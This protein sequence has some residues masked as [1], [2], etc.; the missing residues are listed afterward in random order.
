MV[1]SFIGNKVVFMKNLFY[2]GNSIE[3]VNHI[4]NSNLFSISV[5]IC[6]NRV[7][8]RLLPTAKHL[9]IPIIGVSSHS[10]LERSIGQ[11]PSLKL[12]IM[13][14][15]GII[16]T[17][18]ILTKVDVY[19]FHPGSLERNRGRNPIEWAIL[20][21][22]EKDEMSL[23]KIDEGI[24]TGLLISAC[25]VLIDKEDTAF[26]IRKKMND[27]IP[28]LLPILNDYLE[29]VVK[30][31]Q[32]RPGIYRHRIT[33]KDYT[34]FPGQDSE[35]EIKNKIRSQQDYNGAI[36]IRNGLKVYIKKYTDYLYQL[37]LDLPNGS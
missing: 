4:E 22:W 20:L 17:P 23:H 24:D 2:F 16:I 29:G 19:N 32:L 33:E 6:E 21:G 31:T 10:E 30:A 35:E 26:I 9:G 13:Y 11:Y 36:L 37:G 14:S 25:S 8:E 15:F 5:W 18:S 27:T 3:M 1:I 34:L 28:V 7:I 12:A